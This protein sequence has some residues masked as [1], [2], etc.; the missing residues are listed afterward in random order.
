MTRTTRELSLV[1]IGAGVLAAG[2]AVWAG[3]DFAKRDEEEAQKRAGCTT[4]RYHTF[5]WIHAGRTY[6][7]GPSPA[8]AAH[9]TRGGFGATAARVSGG[10]FGG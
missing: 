4:T 9:T 5:I 7:G 2:Y 10:G 6:A 8:A 3:R 1:L